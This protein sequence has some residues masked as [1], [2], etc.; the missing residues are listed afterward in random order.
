MRLAAKFVAVLAATL[1]VLIG[2]RYL[3][4]G[5]ET[6]RAIAHYAVSVRMSSS[7]TEAPGL[8][9]HVKAD[10]A[11]LFIAWNRPGYDSYSDAGRSLLHLATGKVKCAPGTARYNI[12][13]ERAIRG[14]DHSIR[15]GED[16]QA[17]NGLGDTALH[18]AVAA[19]NHHVIAY[20]LGRGANPAALNADNET[21]VELLKGLVEAG[22]GYDSSSIEPL[23][24]VSADPAAGCAE[25]RHYDKTMASIFVVCPRL[26][27]M[28][29]PGMTTL[30]EHIFSRVE[31]QPDEYL[32]YFFADADSISRKLATDQDGTEDDAEW[33][34]ALV[35]VFY[36]H[37]QQMTLWPEL[38][39]K[40]RVIQ[41]T[42]QR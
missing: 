37:S 12:E 42:R 29:A 16:L 24:G 34:G 8:I 13:A 5:A 30:V 19:G 28:T 23:L 41:L 33:A 40:R 36:T 2:L 10:A 20:L 26:H 25:I 35:G 15:R 3:P 38:P 22:I 31:V 39:E 9:D 14:I 6:Y 1:V 4:V 27:E 18:T 32:V 17:V 11:F 21:P 7:C